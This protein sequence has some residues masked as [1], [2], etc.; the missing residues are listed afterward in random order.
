V[1]WSVSEIEDESL[2][3]KR[4]VSHWET[5][6]AASRS[7]IDMLAWLQLSQIPMWRCPTNHQGWIKR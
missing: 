6:A 3:G 7:V 1:K 5:A 2:I 4:Q